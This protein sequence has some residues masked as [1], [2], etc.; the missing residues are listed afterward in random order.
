MLTHS[1]ARDARFYASQAKPTL[2]EKRQLVRL[3][4]KDKKGVS[5]NCFPGMYEEEQ[6]EYAYLQAK[7][8]FNEIQA[9][10]YKT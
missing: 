2:F 5:V 8:H 6:F 10:T 7:K 3:Y 4:I 9:N 1:E